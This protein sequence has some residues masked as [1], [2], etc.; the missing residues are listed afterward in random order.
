MLLGLKKTLNVGQQHVTGRK[1]TGAQPQQ[2]PAFLL[3]VPAGAQNSQSASTFYSW[4]TVPK[5][6]ATNTID[7][8]LM[9]IVSLFRAYYFL[10]GSLSKI[11]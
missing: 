6:N 5:L 8:M 2:L 10:R 9:N 3:A 7:T 1:Q 11:L 4:V